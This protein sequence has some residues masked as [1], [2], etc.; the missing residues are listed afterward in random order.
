MDRGKFVTGSVAAA[1]PALVR[2]NVSSTTLPATDQAPGAISESLIEEA[3]FPEGFL[4]G[5]ATASYQV[6][7]AWN[8]DGKGLFSEARSVSEIGHIDSV[9]TLMVRGLRSARQARLAAEE[10]LPNLRGSS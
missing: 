1:R 8:E 7:G 6:E 3:R 5:A 9:R 10:L 2:E 4:W